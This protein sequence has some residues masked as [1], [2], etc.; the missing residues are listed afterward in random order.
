VPLH[1]IGIVQGFVGIVDKAVAR[2]I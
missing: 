1:G 2:H